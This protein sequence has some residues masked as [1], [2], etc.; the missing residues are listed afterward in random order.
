MSVLMDSC[1]VIRGSKSGLEV[2]L[3]TDQAP[4]LLDIV[5]DTCYY[6][7]NA[8]KK[9]SSKFGRHLELMF[10]HI[11][12]YFKWST[13]LREL[14]VQHAREVQWHSLAECLQF[15]SGHPEAHGC[16]QPLLLSIPP[17]PGP[18]SLPAHLCTTWMMGHEMRYEASRES[19]VL[20]WQLKGKEEKKSLW[21]PPLWT[22]STQSFF[23]SSAVCYPSWRSS[24]VPKQRAVTTQATRWAAPADERFHGLLC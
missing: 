23:T 17:A 20:R 7:H 19:Y 16:K 24:H 11:H 2:R 15:S 10:I 22:G 6:A 13:D 21:R 9:F 5:G 3:R 12:T 4:H 1:N 18:R 8:G 14:H